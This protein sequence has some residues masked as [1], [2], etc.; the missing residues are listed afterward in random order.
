MK[1]ILIIAGA[2][3]NFMKIA[4]IVRA[5]EQSKKLEYKIV[6]TGQ[7]Y[8]AGMSQTFFDDLC[9]PA[10]H[11]NLSV[12]SGS[13]AVQT[14]NIMIKFEE[15]CLTEKPDIVA[16]VGDVN[17][18]V[19]CGL[20][21]KKLCIALAHVEAGLRSNDRTMPEEINR[22]VTDSISDYLFVTEPSGVENLRR[23][24]HAEKQISYVGHV[25]ID[26]LFHQLDMLTSKKMSPE[27]QAL[28]NR[29]SGNYACMTMHRPANVD[30]RETLEKLLA[31]VGAVAEAAP[32]IFPCHPR[33]RKNIEMFGLTGRFKTLSLGNDSVAPGMYL[34]EPLGF[35]D[36][37]YLWK[38]A[39]LVLTDSGGLQEE[40]TALKIPCITM[41]E[42]TE[43][44]VTAEVGSNVVVGSDGDKIISWGRSAF[45]GAWKESRVPDLWDGHA[46]ERIVKVLENS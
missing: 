24:G 18:T 37:L 33:T 15:V 45:A 22:I 6:H 28:K 14:A 2:R 19:A 11:Y 39:R 23:E 21:A 38:D 27:I 40:T 43:R 3:P 30:N 17:S 5:L 26:N 10:P 12:G 4:P 42:S 25:M 36:F 44:P 46:S 20:V 1:K 7:H 41:R 8:D 32:V 29:L 34:M 13:H 9:I 16:V 31:A 35:D